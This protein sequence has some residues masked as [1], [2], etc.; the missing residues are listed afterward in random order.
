MVF[1]TKTIVSQMNPR[2]NA[3]SVPPKRTSP[4]LLLSYTSRLD[5]SILSLVE[6][7]LF[8]KKIVINLWKWHPWLFFGS[9]S[10]VLLFVC[11]QKTLLR[12]YFISSDVTFTSKSVSKICLFVYLPLLS[13]FYFP[14]LRS[15]LSQFFFSSKKVFFPRK[16]EKSKKSENWEIKLFFL[17]P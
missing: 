13:L 2:S 6:D 1:S 8:F 12:F 4:W 3:E 7:F 14:H 16:C 5:K 10:T 17:R 15:K 9:H 11:P